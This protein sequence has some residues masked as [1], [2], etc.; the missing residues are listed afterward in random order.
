MKQHSRGNRSFQ[1]FYL[2]YLQEHRRRGTKVLH[3][4]GTSLVLPFLI[5]ALLTHLW[6]LI[7]VA[8]VQA[9][10]LAWI[11]HFLIEHNH[12]TTFQHPWLSLR[13]DWQMWWD[14]MMG[15]LRW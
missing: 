1:A 3:F 8:I 14:L 12:P 2:Q 10:A 5:A 6:W 13:G 4:L 15:N 11:G 7:A 9:Y